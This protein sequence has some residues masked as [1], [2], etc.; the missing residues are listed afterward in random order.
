VYALM[1]SK[2]KENNIE[3]ETDL[4]PLLG[5]VFMDPKAIHRS[6]LN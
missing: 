3:I 4:D 2:A 1:Q 5:E 6:L